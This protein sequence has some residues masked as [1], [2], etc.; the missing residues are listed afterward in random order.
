MQGIEPQSMDW[1]SKMLTAKP[2]VLVSV[3][4][5]FDDEI[6]DILQKKSGPSREGRDK[7]LR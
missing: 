1:E 4:L 5:N 2:Q 7:V 3:D 6:K